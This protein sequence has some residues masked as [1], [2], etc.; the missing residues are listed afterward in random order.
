MIV[1][2]IHVQSSVNNRQQ[3]CISHCH[4]SLHQVQI[5]GIFVRTKEKKENNVIDRKLSTPHTHS[6]QLYI[7][8]LP[9]NVVSSN[10]SV[11]LSIFYLWNVKRRNRWEFATTSVLLKRTYREMLFELFWDFIILQKILWSRQLNTMI[12]LP[13]IFSDL[14][15]LQ[16]FS[17]LKLRGKLFIVWMTLGSKKVTN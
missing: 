14:W 3:H 1:G 15:Q 4:Y 7:F 13:P 2:S 10:M 8:M 12:Q 16:K 9:V 6:F 11:H 5:T 17:W